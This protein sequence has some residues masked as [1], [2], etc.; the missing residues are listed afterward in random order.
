MAQI[1]LYVEDAVAKRLSSIARSRNLSV[2]KYVAGVI[3]ESLNN[4]DT[5]EISKKQLLQ[6][7]LGAIDDPTFVEPPDIP[8]VA[9][10][11]RRY[12]LI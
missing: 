6:S 11:V 7:L 9:E 5:E 1:S 8:M 10:G 3:K 2:S 4:D 12:D